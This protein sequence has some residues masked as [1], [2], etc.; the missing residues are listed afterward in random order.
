MTATIISMH[1]A[2]S[3][4]IGLARA[5]VWDVIVDP[6]PPGGALWHV[7]VTGPRPSG[8]AVD[9]HRHDVAYSESER[10]NCRA[11][12]LKAVSDQ[13]LQIALANARMLGEIPL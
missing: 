12:A 7:I 4:E 11:A 3:Q 13:R 10:E 2:D 8:W 5:E 1:Y 9:P 6:A